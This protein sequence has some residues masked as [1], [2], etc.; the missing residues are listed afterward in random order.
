MCWAD[1]LWALCIR[2]GKIYIDNFLGELMISI[3]FAIHYKYSSQL[4]G[5][6]NFTE[7]DAEFWQ[8]GLFLPSINFL[9]V[10]FLSSQ[11]PACILWLTS[12]TWPQPLQWESTDTN[13]NGNIRGFF[14]R[15]PG[16]LTAHATVEEDGH[17]GLTVKQ[18]L[19]RQSQI[20]Y[21]K[22]RLFS[23]AFIIR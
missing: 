3:L 20:Y 8:T 6:S 17:N 4:L 12:R 11:L 1:P 19:H 23:L 7:T 21:F 16:R 5:E 2:K 13:W 15:H 22:S 14:I 10:L 9:L 18:G